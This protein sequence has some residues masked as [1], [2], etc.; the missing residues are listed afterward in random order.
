MAQAQRRQ[1]KVEDVWPE[2]VQGIERML[3]KL[4]SINND[5]WMRMYR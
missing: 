5:S 1:H 3:V 4:E 2:L